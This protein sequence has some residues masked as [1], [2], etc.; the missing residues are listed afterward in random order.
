M[1]VTVSV[2]VSVIAIIH[3]P[4]S[5]WDPSDFVL[6]AGRFGFCVVQWIG[7]VSGFRKG[8]LIDVGNCFRKCFHLSSAT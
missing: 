8:R 6:G 1:H 7:A 5:Y 3:L 2:I 4:V